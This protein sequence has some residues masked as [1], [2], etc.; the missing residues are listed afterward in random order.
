V[1]SYYINRADQFPVDFRLWFQCQVKK[2]LGQLRQAGSLLAA[3]PTLKGYR[4]HLANWLVF[5][6]R[7]QLYRT[8][9]ALGADLVRGAVDLGLPFSVVVFDSWFLHN[10]LI[11]A[12]QAVD[13][14]WIGGCPKD[15]LVLI[16]NQWMQLQEYLKTIPPTAYRLTRVH[17]HVYWAFTQVLTFKSLRRRPIRMVASFDNPELKGEPR[18]LTTNR[19]DWERTRILLTYGDRWPTETF[20]EDV[21][22]HLGFEDYQLHKLRGI[23]RHWYLGFAAYSLLGDQG[24][25]GRSRHGVRAPFESTGQRCRAVA[26]E[27]LGD[28]VEWIAQRLEEGV[29]TATIV[30]TLLA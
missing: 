11:D 6:I 22:G 7:Q 23:R 10:E 12:I 30:Q 8:K 3:Q 9:T 5:H 19:K 25:P 21:K 29:P 18:L 15:R 17:D 16:D 14:D 20:N 1:T 27:V 2:E 4:Q 13:K 24:H 28:L 26:N